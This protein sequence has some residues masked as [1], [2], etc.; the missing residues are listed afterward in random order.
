[1]ASPLRGRSP[2]RDLEYA[3]L[4]REDALE[5]RGALLRRMR[6]AV[7]ALQAELDRT[8]RDHEEEKA[9]VCIDGA[10]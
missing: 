6:G 2:V 4:S 9:A 8:R 3:L 10:R 1:M 5:D 7:E